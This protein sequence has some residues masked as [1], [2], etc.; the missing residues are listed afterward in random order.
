[1]L[2]SMELAVDVSVVRDNGIFDEII[3]ILKVAMEVNFG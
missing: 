2:V 3:V 1:M